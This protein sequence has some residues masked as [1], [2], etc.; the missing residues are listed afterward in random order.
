VI[1]RILNAFRP[2]YSLPT[3]K[4]VAAVVAMVAL[5]RGWY[6]EHQRYED[7]LELARGT[8]ETAQE[9]RTTTAGR[10]RVLAE[11]VEIA[12]SRHAV[13][14]AWLEANRVTL[15]RHLVAGR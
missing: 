14:V 11:R 7:M 9:C 2:P 5:A 10:I 12:E 15:P 3:W 6:D 8:D 1:G 4:E 13:I